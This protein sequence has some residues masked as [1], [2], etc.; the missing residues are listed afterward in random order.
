M[1]GQLALE[2]AAIDLTN[3]RQMPASALV[4]FEVASGLLEFFLTHSLS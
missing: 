2:P 3:D 4:G 1:R